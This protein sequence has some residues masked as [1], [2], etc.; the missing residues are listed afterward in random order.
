MTF[1]SLGSRMAR[2]FSSS[3]CFAIAAIRSLADCAGSAVFCSL[4]F[5]LG[6]SQ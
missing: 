6:F 2:A 3:S 1:S 5:G 4:G